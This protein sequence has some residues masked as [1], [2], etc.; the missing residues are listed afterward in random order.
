MYKVKVNDDA[1]LKLKARIVPHGNDDS[2]KQLMWTDCCMCS[3]LGIRVVLSTAAYRSWRIVC[4]DVKTAFLKT[5][6]TDRSVYV[7]PPR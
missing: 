1:P 6:P 7:I 2:D 4:I 3:P 5:G